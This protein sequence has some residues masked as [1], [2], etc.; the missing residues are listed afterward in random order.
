MTGWTRQQAWP[1]NHVKFL[2]SIA[3]EL[4]EVIEK[5]GRK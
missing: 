1:D 2:A 5:H 3:I 4:A